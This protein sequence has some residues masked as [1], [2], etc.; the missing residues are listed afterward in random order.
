MEDGM[1]RSPLGIIIT[2]SVS[3]SKRSGMIEQTETERV[4]KCSELMLKCETPG[5]K[6][7]VLERLHKYFG[8][9]SPESLYRILR[10]SSAKKTRDLR[11]SW[12]RWREPGL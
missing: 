3:E 6:K 4:F 7:K 5:E 9:V 11:R 2:T 10:A 12:K 1:I 8:H